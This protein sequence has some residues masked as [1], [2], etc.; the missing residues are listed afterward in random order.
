MTTT[1]SDSTID[2]WKGSAIDWRSHGL[3]VFTAAERE[4][5]DAGLRHYRSGAPRDFAQMRKA[6]L[7]LDGLAPVLADAGRAIQ[8]GAGFMMF[9]GLDV[10]RYSRDELALIFF[11]IGLHI[12]MPMIQSHQGEYLGHVM[13]L[14]DIEKSPRGYH[15]G[16]HMGMH[17]DSCDVVGLMCMHGARSGGASRIANAKAIMGEIERSRPDLAEVLRT[18]MF[19]RRMEQ[20]AEHGNGVVCSPGRIP[21]YARASD[22]QFSCYFLGGYIQRAVKA[23]DAV[24]SSPE[25]EALDLVNRLAES[26]EYYLDMQFTDGDMQ[27]LNNRVMLHG[28]THYEDGKDIM[29]RRHLV[30]MWLKMPTWPAMPDAQVFHTAADRQA[31]GQRRVPLMD[32]PSRY[33][34]EKARQVEALAA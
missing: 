33:L 24:L 3:H 2:A 8:D 15:T 6:D 9:R 13:N 1:T 25:Q 4:V 10:H 5:I 16:G 7:P 12:G 11:A 18:G 23:G 26:P 21:I 19:F 20:D 29:D 30:R 34:A 22:G 31:W 27:F 17:T 32:M 14:S 28:R